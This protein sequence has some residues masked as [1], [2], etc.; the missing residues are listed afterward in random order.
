MRKKYIFSLFVKV[1][2]YLAFFYFKDIIIVIFLIIDLIIN[3]AI[4]I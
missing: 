1:Y 3:N 2:N 4:L